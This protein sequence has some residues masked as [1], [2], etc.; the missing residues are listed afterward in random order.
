MQEIEVDRFDLTAFSFTIEVV[1]KKFF[2]VVRKK[3]NA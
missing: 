3:L 1:D 2:L